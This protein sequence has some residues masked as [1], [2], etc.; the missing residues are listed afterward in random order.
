M[1]QLV[2]LLLMMVISKSSLLVSADL[3]PY[4]NQPYEQRIKDFA[5]LVVKYPGRRFLLKPQSLLD[6]ILVQTE[7]QK[8]SGRDKSF[9]WALLNSTLT[10][11][12]VVWEREFASLPTNF[13]RRSL[14]C[15]DFL[16][17]QDMDLRK[18]A[19]K[20]A[21]CNAW[22]AYFRAS[23]RLSFWSQSYLWKA[24]GLSIQYA[25]TTHSLHLE[26]HQENET[27]EEYAFFQGWSRFALYLETL[28]F[29]TTGLVTSPISDRFLPDCY[30][31]GAAH[32]RL[33]DL[34]P[35][36][37]LLVSYLIAGDV[38]LF[39]HLVSYLTKK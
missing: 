28:N 17:P 10:I 8:D 23:S 15:A 14:R 34:T 29:P 12:P 31:L 24:H 6:G 25:L 7:W 3:P 18:T 27:P 5:P 13:D 4:W 22:L 39:P 37:Y 2:K 16:L 19:L 9:H 30:P 11:E 1:I 36:R 33:E 21:V 32:C 38:Q 20:Q 35:E 26:N